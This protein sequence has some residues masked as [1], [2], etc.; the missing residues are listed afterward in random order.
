MGFVREIN[1]QQD[2]FMIS[3]LIFIDFLLCYFDFAPSLVACLLANMTGFV[4][5][6]VFY[7]EPVEAVMVRCAFSTVWLTIN[8][9]ILQLIITK[10]GMIYTE[11]EVLR[12][13]ND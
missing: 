8:L 5:R 4:K 2:E 9:T 10:V 12:K 6:A 3:M 1:S 13:G 11:A 7:E